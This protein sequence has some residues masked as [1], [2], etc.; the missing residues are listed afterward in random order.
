[1][2]LCA[3][4][5]IEVGLHVTLYSLL[6]NTSDFLKIYL[7]QSGYQE[8]DIKRLHRT[9]QPFNGQYELILKSFDDQVF[10]RY[11][12]IQGNKFTYVRLMLASLLPE[13]RVIYLDSDL[14]VRKDLGSLFRQ[15]LDG[16]VLGVSGM[17]SV[18]WSL[19]KNFFVSLGMNQAAKY[20]N[21]GVMLMDLDQWR[22]KDITKAC[23]DF[24]DQHP[25][26]LGAA[27]QTVLNYIFY[28]NNFLEVDPTYNH[29]LYPDTPSLAA[30]TSGH[31]FHFVGS[32]KPWDILGEGVHSN[33]R[34]FAETLRKTEFRTYK[35]YFDLTPYRLKR[36]IR[37]AK[38]YFKYL[39]R[40]WLRI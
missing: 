1:M 14:L 33:Y 8:R 16:H 39:R 22:Q 36:S 25:N 29:A 37:L 18:K 26:Q 40:K 15:D 5:N 11:K 17:G 34:L 20:F 7:V 12:G 38:S 31:I 35:T 19:E 21:A 9:L 32:P 23:M 4:K 30:N 27:D 3:D 6:E 10:K 13:S 24:A 28:E 2:A